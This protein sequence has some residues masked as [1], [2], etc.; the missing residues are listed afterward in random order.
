MLTHKMHQ[1]KMEMFWPKILA[2][3]FATHI[4]KSRDTKLGQKCHAKK[5]FNPIE[6][7]NHKHSCP[8]KNIL[9]HQP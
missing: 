5:D 8:F 7:H 9:C 2:H 3:F 6:K 4:F 1:N